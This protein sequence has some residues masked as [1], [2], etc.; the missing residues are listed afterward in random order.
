M[1]LELEG[2]ELEP[3]ELELLLELSEPLLDELELSDLVSEEDFDSDFESDPFLPAPLPF[4][5]A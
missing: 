2:L 1:L 3:L 5:F 4:D